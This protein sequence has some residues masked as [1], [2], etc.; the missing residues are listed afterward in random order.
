[1]MLPKYNWYCILPHHFILPHYFLYDLSALQK[2]VAS[3]PDA[4]S[5][6]LACSYMIRSDME[7]SRRKKLISGAG[8]LSRNI[9]C[10]R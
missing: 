6:L 5:L 2:S 10:R 9:G 1:M 3:C 4:T 8:I 7:G